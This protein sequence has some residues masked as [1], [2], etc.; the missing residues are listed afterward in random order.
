MEENRK[1]QIKK[2]M[3]KGFDIEIDDR[4]IEDYNHR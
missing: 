1:V 3:K 4:Y 2:F